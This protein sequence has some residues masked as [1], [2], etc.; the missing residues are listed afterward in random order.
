VMRGLFAHREFRLLLIGQ[1]ASTVGDRIVF[2]AL[3]LYVTGIGS[4]SDVGIVLAC[5]A[6]PL[7]CFVLLGGV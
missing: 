6:V 1:S 3:A 2:V 7:V 4:P 5:N